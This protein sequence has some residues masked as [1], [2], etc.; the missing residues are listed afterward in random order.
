LKQCVKKGPKESIEERAGAEK[1]RFLK[2]NANP[3]MFLREFEARLDQMSV[4]LRMAFSG[5][6]REG[7]L[8]SGEGAIFLGALDREEAR[9]T[10]ESLPNLIREDLMKAQDEVGKMEPLFSNTPCADVFRDLTQGR[11]R[12]RRRGHFR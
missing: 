12:V 3:G 7:S 4:S 8:T 10:I 1:K 6:S 5:G 2:K 9:R 11:T